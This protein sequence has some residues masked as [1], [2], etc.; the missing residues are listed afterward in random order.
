MEL[1]IQLIW[2]VFRICS[3]VQISL[4]ITGNVDN[5][6]TSLNVVRGGEVSM[7]TTGRIDRGSLI[8]ARE[9]STA[10]HQ[11]LLDK[12]AHHATVNCE[13]PGLRGLEWIRIENLDVNE[14]VV[15]IVAIESRVR[16]EVLSIETMS[17]GVVIRDRDEVSAK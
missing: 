2:S 13:T 17:E 9:A 5:V 10:K 15:L 14:R 8:A 6:L 12:V 16:P 3:E 4:A 7:E 1:L 11:M